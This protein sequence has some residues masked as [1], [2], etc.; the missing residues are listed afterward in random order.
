MFYSYLSLK[1]GIHVITYFFSA[2]FLMSEC[3]SI[4]WGSY[5]LF[6]QS[7]TGDVPDLFCLPLKYTLHPFY[8]FST[9][10][11]PCAGSCTLPRALRSPV[12]YGRQQSRM[13][14]LR[15]RRCWWGREGETGMHAAVLLLNSPVRVRRE[16]SQA[17]RQEYLDKLP[18]CRSK[19]SGKEKKNQVKKSKYCHIP[20]LV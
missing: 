9:S 19:R 18:H 11:D 13:C 6:V 10:R 2:W 8:P 17:R 16:K 20:Y 5:D 7:P 15:A 1:E 3:Y 4:V 14:A 12:W